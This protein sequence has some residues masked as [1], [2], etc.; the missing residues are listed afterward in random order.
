MKKII[1]LIAFM[2]ITFISCNNKEQDIAVPKFS[3]VNR[4]VSKSQAKELSLSV[5][6]PIFNSE[7]NIKFKGKRPQKV[8]PITEYKDVQYI[9]SDNDTLMYVIN[10]GENDGYMIMS[11]DKGSFPI[12]SFVDTGR[13][14]VSAIDKSTSFGQWIEEKK[15]EI[16]EK[17]K[18]PIDTT[19]VNYK[20]WQGVGND[21][22]TVSIE[23]TK[24]LPRRNS[25]SSLKQ[26]MTGTRTYSTCKATVYPYTGVYYTWSQGSGY[27]NN[28]PIAGALA[29]CP[30]VAVGLLCVDQWYPSAFDFYSMPYSVT[31]NNENSV[32]K[33]FRAIGDKIPGYK[34]SITSSGATPYNILTGI[35]ELGFKDAKCQPYE[36]ETAYNNL[37]KSLSVLFGG[38]S[39]N[40]G[41][42][43]F[44]DGYYEMGWK[45]TR[46]TKFLWWKTKVETWYEYSDFLWMNWGWYGSQN[47]WFESNSWNG[48]ENNKMMYIDLYPM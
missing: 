13:V 6:T 29:G 36:F 31:V 23:L 28:A 44:C 17:L 35:Q 22:C 8:S 48:F 19:N 39:S 47:G 10:F 32:S 5:V 26:K 41:H 37:Q 14:D 2:G 24:E 27:N 38:Y 18:Q 45:I 25:N 3:N 1:Y 9:I 11:G 15:V 46:T 16:S 42:I 34:W 30:A 7:S 33:M 43:W 12:I 20:L 4:Q 21:S 40:G